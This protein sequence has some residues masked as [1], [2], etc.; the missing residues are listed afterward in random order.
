MSFLFVAWQV[1]A[2]EVRVAVGQTRR[3]RTSSQASSPRFVT[4]PQLP[5]PRTQFE[6]GFYIWYTAPGFKSLELST[7]D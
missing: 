7:G 2:E 5:S 4:S 6:F 1:L 3:L